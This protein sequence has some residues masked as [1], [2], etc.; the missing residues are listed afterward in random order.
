[1]SELSQDPSKPSKKPKSIHEGHR[2]R[3]KKRFLE[4]GMDAFEPH[5]ILEMLLYYGIPQGDTNPIAHR[6]L[7]TFGSFA[8]VLDAPIESLETVKGIGRSSAILLK[9]VPQL[10]RIYLDDLQ[11]SR[12]LLDTKDIADYIMPKFVGRKNEAVVLLLLNSRAEVL[13]CDVM[14]EGSVREVAIYVRN[15]V[16][17]AMRH[18]ASSAVL[19]HNHPSGN[20]M[21]S[22]GD[23]A[24]TANIYDALQP[25]G[26]QLLD[27]LIVADDG[28]TY[29][30]MWTSGLLEKA[31]HNR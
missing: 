2:S 22:A 4:Q 28:K 11:T 13:F 3:M 7:D 20:T 14:N 23:L 30:S 26:V 1:M 31:L 6:L 27:H 29:L 12:P 10:A 9:M 19:A 16:H 21:P 18:N 17:M 24:V 8:K 5:E 15:I 25:V